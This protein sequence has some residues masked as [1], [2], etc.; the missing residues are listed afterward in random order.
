M[1]SEPWGCGLD[2]Y[3]GSAALVG[4]WKEFP[5]H[6]LEL[7]QGTAGLTQLD[8]ACLGKGGGKELV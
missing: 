4:C 5:P 6:P 8:S 7:V 1:S 2:P 3:T